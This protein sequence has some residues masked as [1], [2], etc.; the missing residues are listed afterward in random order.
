[1]ATS[2]RMPPNW[3][4]PKISDTVLDHIG[5]TPLI[6]INKLASSLPC[7]VLAKCE[8]FNSGGSV[9][10]R[11]GKRMIL[12]AEKAGKIKPGDTIIEP[13]SGNTGIGL[14]L[15]ALTRGYRTIITLPEKMSDEKMNMLK[16]L[17]AEII[18]T[19]TE[20]AWDAPESHIGVA[21]RLQAK[22]PNSHILDQYKNPSNPNAHYEGTAEEIL[23]QCD[24]ELDMLVCGAGTGGTITGIARKL[25]EKLPNVKVVGVDPM[26]SILAQPSSLNAAAPPNLVEG[27]GY[28]F[29]PDVLD[30]S[31]VDE[32]IKTDDEVSFKMARR[33]I[34]EE[35]L[36]VGGS[37]G[38][39]MHACLLAAASLGRGQRVVVI[40]PDSTRNYMSKFLSDEWMVAKGFESAS[41]LSNADE[42][43]RRL[44]ALID[45]DTSGSL[46]PP[47]ADKTMPV[48]R[49]GAQHT[50]AEM[51]WD[52]MRTPPAS[53]VR[54]VRGTTDLPGLTAWDGSQLTC[55][56]LAWSFM[57]PPPNTPT[58]TPRSSRSASK[59]SE[60]DNHMVCSQMAFAF[61]KSPVSPER[62]ASTA[63]HPMQSPC[64]E[65][66]AGHLGMPNLDL[67]AI[68]ASSDH[69]AQ[70][71][72]ANHSLSEQASLAST[73]AASPNL[74]PTELSGHM[75]P[76]MGKTQG[77]A[78][79]PVYSDARREYASSLARKDSHGL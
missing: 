35:G 30:R 2:S 53:P 17:G 23:Y 16:A 77:A 76:T 68:R 52:F 69:S 44:M 29:I 37:S 28:D 48:S 9:K 51:A 66:T 3:A 7:S 1:M 22:I 38:A 47:L 46:R 70:R 54:K 32:W 41:L 60:S 11:I 73:V 62:K 74:M 55:A 50:C 24:G 58:S 4:R 25:K 14:A 15:T 20:A 36:M 8:F 75:P 45:E 19:P 43:S 78:L 34:K 71:P 72:K 61:M 18:R 13:T 56:A 33:L 49:D 40:L 65:T 59:P 79:P 31:L 42:A 26:G 67:A 63:T 10:D 39:A 6:R 21:K 12:D 57:K 5:S 27:I 64:S